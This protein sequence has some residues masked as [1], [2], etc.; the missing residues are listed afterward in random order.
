MSKI[1]NR[2]AREAE[3]EA[4]REGR[5]T[6]AVRYRPLKGKGSYRRKAKHA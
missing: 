4:R 6:R 5:I 3:L 1:I 2:L